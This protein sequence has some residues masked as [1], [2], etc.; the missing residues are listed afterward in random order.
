MD[1]LPWSSIVRR[2]SG[3]ELESGKVP[4]GYRQARAC[5]SPGTWG[6]DDVCFL[7]FLEYALRTSLDNVT[8]RYRGGA[9]QPTTVTYIF[10]WVA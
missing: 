3:F 1:L 8:E 5:A 7:A 10:T 9:G 2:S 4:F 6:S